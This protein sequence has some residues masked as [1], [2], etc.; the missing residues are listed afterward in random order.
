MTTLDIGRG[1][2]HMTDYELTEAEQEADNDYMDGLLLT[3]D[4]YNAGYTAGMAANYSTCPPEYN[5]DEGDDW[6]DGFCDCLE[7]RLQAS[8]GRDKAQEVEW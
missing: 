3:T 4:A 1:G 2:D 6:I 7:T 5:A 8:L